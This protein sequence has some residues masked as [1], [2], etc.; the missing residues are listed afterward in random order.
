MRRVFLYV[1]MAASCVVTA[2]LDVIIAKYTGYEPFSLSTWIVV[3]VGAFLVGMAASSGALA[4]AYLLHVRPN[5]TDAFAMVWFGIACMGLILFLQYWTYILPDGRYAHRVADFWRFTDL[6][7]RTAHMRIGRSLQNDT[8][9][10]G[11]FGYVQLG[12]QALAFLAAGLGVSGLIAQLPAC[13]S[14]PSYLRKVRETSNGELP[15]EQAETLL[16]LMQGPFDDVQNV[17]S[18]KA[19]KQSHKRTDKRAK[20]SYRLY[21]CPRCKL[22]AVVASAQVFDGKHWQ[23]V[24]RATVRRNLAAGTTLWT[25][26]K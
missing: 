14:C 7:V 1:G 2:V 9:E 18:W 22:E 11:Q 24:P 3:P 15:L 21:E 8:G 17:V 6:S 26:F 10:V 20:V 4:S 25:A 13:K 16:A 23:D 12:L 19:E 5:L